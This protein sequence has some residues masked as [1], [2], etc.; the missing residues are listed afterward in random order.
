VWRRWW[1]GGLLGIA[2]AASASAGDRFWVEARQQRLHH[3]HSDMVR[4]ARRSLGAVVSITTVQPAAQSAAARGEP[5]G[6]GEPQKGLGAGFLI[7]PDGYILT[8]H[9][10]VDGASEVEVTLLGPGGRPERV[11]ALV[12]GTDPH[13]DLALLQVRVGRKLPVLTLGSARHVEVADWVVVIGNPF[14]L[15]HSVSVGVVSFKGRTDITPVG[16]NGYFDYLQTDASINPGNSGGPIL[17]LDGHVVAIANA[18]N[19]TGQGIGFGIPIDLVK[20]VLPQLRERGSVRRG[21]LGVTV[22]DITPEQ[23]ASLDAA[24]RRGVIVSEVVDG[25]PAARA[26]IKVGDVICRVGKARV[27]RAHALRWKVATRGAG[28]WL[29]LQVRRGERPLSVRVRLEDVPAG[30]TGHRGGS[31]G[32]GSEAGGASP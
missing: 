19:V 30:E 25:G 6:S 15:G 11:P 5:A 22:Q 8:S 9:H 24:A 13:T 28:R 1:W 18:V 4:V 12:I 32:G 21:W 26:G 3:Q 16:R 10:V 17:D 31:A 29:S 20:P 2:I 23:A 27:E 14:G 7:H